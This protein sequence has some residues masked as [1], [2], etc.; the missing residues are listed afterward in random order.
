MAEQD[1][2]NRAIML[3]QLNT[4]RQIVFDITAYYLEPLSGNFERLC[5]LASL[6][7]DKGVYIHER[8]GV[9]Y[10]ELPVAEALVKCHEELLERVLELPLA[11][12]EAD[13]RAFQSASAAPT[14]LFQ[15]LMHHPREFLPEG[16]PD[17]LKELFYSN[18]K[19]LRELLKECNPELQSDT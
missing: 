7:N 3:N 15:K 2:R 12:Q 10:G 6:R 1:A 18:L 16:S 19:V 8:L 13:L 14:E 17:Y 4:H 5:Y 11:Q 9:A